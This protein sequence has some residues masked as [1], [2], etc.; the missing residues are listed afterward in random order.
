MATAPDGQGLSDDVWGSPFL[1]QPGKLHGALA[2]LQ[3]GDG[4]LGSSLQWQWHS[5]GDL[6]SQVQKFKTLATKLHELTST[7]AAPKHSNFKCSLLLSGNSLL[8]FSML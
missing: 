1:V 8:S 3:E 7:D 6:L 2:E 5:P 4:H